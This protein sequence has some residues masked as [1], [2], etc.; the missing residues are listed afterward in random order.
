MHHLELRV[1]ELM[2]LFNSLD[3]APFLNKDLDQAAE[4]FIEAWAREF[5]PDSR[6]QITIHLENPNAEGNA[7][8]L[9]TEAIHNHFD[10]KA[11][12]VRGELR[13][14]LKRGRTSLFIGLAFVA[15]CLIAADAIA[16]L[17]PSTVSTIARESLT[18]IGWVAMWRP[19]EIFLYDWWPLVRRIRVYKNLRYAR[20]RVIQ[21]K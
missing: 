11:G 21:G 9:M 12:L 6:L 8:V 5:A 2:Q 19:V 16:Q 17:D 18:I 10:Y 13:D 15:A 3:P 7:T 20:V 14:L 1:S 4:V